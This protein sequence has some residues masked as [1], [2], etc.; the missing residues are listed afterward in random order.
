M[1]VVVAAALS[2]AATAC[3]AD[4]VVVASSPPATAAPTVV[5]SAIQPSAGVPTGGLISFADPTDGFSIGYPS[6]WTQGG[7][8]GGTAVMFLS[9]LATGDTFRENLNVVVEDVPAGTTLDQY[10]A[11][12]KA[13][14]PNVIQGFQMMSENPV[15]LGTLPGYQIR[16]TGTYSG[17]Q[18]EWMQVLAVGNSKGYVLTYTAR[19]ETFDSYA[20]DAW[21]AMQSF[22]LT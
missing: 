15:S 5:P 10:V 19:P 7:N 11:S 17:N 16:Y 22:R 8:T 6:T 13:N 12:N 9:P 14:L 2:A 20:A 4:T 18:L 21:A 1:G 3:G